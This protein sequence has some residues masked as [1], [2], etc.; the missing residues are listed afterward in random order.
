MTA[1]NS[2]GVIDLATENCE[3]HDV[4]VE[5]RDDRDGKRK[6]IQE[7]EKLLHNIQDENVD[8]LKHQNIRLVHEVTELLRKLDIKQ[9][10]CE[11]IVTEN[12]TLKGTMQS[13]EGEKM[14]YVREVKSVI[15]KSLAAREVMSQVWDEKSNG[16]NE[17]SDNEELEE[18]Q[19]G[20]VWD[21]NNG[22][23]DDDE[24]HSKT[25]RGEDVEKRIEKKK[26]L[27]MESDDAGL[28]QQVR[29]LQRCVEQQHDLKAEKVN[30]LTVEIEQAKQERNAL[31]Q[32][33]EQL[34][35]QTNQIGQIIRD[36]DAEVKN[37]KEEVNGLRMSLS[38]V[39]NAREVLQKELD[40]LRDENK[41]MQEA[42]IT[43]ERDFKRECDEK[44]DTVHQLQEMEARLKHKMDKH[45]ELNG[46]YR[47]LI[48][49]VS[50]SLGSC[51]AQV[52][53]NETSLPEP[54]TPQP[55]GVWFDRLMNC[56][57]PFATECFLGIC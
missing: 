23:V 16:S 45:T 22:D 38:K 36:R 11:T 9:V 37:F 2:E 55:R 15:G 1:K 31:Q 21:N 5:L 25:L 8:V 13:S 50:S 17:E 35:E 53:P 12:E 14:V 3:L 26:G 34:Q 47:E 52:C 7:L 32:E 20:G 28:H 41:L 29:V 4:I 39:I 46:R 49:R 57:A 10:F 30:A 54:D 48:R 33:K 51:R 24:D 56:N 6:K 43:Y 18:K 44:R 19:N 40:E 27:G 42:L